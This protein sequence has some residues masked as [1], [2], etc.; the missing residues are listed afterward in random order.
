MRR[1]STSATVRMGWPI[2]NRTERKKNTRPNERRYRPGS[3]MHL[4]G[5]PQLSAGRPDVQETPEGSGRNRPLLCGC[6]PRKVII[7]LGSEHESVE[8]AKRRDP[9][10]KAFSARA[11]EG[12]RGGT[13]EPSGA[14][15]KCLS[16][17]GT[18]GGPFPRPPEGEGGGEQMVDGD[19]KR[20]RKECLNKRQPI[21]S[22]IM[23]IK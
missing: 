20:K 6:L 7:E 9:N 3:S 16:T 5:E 12:F 17:S 13:P 22:R 4:G 8:G 11:D 1:V 23:M 14:N 2:R 15:G 10:E 21:R 19:R 18:N